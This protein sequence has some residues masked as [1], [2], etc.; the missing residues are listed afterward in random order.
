[1]RTPDLPVVVI[2]GGFAGAAAARDIAAAGH[3]VHLVE[4]RQRLGG[5]TWTTEFVGTAIELGGTWVHPS[6]PHV[7]AE[8]ERYGIVVTEDSWDFDVAVVG[9]ELA[10]VP[11]E[12][13]FVRMRELTCDASSGWRS[14]I[15][16]PMHFGQSINAASKALDA[17]SLATVLRSGA[18]DAPSGTSGESGGDSGGARALEADLDLF[19]SLLYEIAGSPLE[20]ASALG[21]ARWLAL[22]DWDADK[23]Y[24][25]NRFRI[26][27]GTRQLLLHL[28]EEVT[29]ELGAV[30]T[31]VEHDADRCEVALSDGRVIGASAV[32]AAVPIN[33][34]PRIDFSPDLPLPTTTP[35]VF[36]KPHQDKL[37][38]HVVTDAGRVF[39]HLPE[40][41]PLSFFWTWHNFSDGTQLLM[42]INANPDLDLNSRPAVEDVLRRQVPGLRQVLDVVAHSWSQ[43]PFSGGGNSSS[44]LG[45]MTSLLPWFQQPHGRVLFAG[46]DIADGWFGYIDGAIESG[47]RAAAQC[48]EMQLGGSRQ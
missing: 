18:P 13:V 36:G 43:D 23:W 28:V 42:A 3:E 32:I 48:L 41:S 27:G 20:E 11:P 39:G 15:E 16:D 37:F 38:A 1:M 7:W 17:T 45:V 4:G 5:R 40:G 22:C 19:G 14:A 10:L 9:R 35:A 6:Q 26:S 25:T 12:T 2:G 29:V 33:C 44:R 8:I 30:V 24:D 31:R 46:A 21:F 47:R 34:L